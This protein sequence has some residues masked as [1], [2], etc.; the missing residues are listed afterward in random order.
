MS[1]KTVSK[2]DYDTF[3]YLTYCLMDKIDQS[4]VDTIDYIAAPGRGGL[5][6]GV[7][8]SHYFNKPFI[9]VVWSNKDT[10]LQHHN[11]F[12]A[13]KLYT[14]S[15]ILLVKNISNSGKTLIEITK[16]LMYADPHPNIPSGQLYT[17]TVFQR[18]NSKFQCAFFGKMI[19]DETWIQ[20]PWESV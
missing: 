18:H 3:H 11:E 10:T 9:P 15:N 20:F 19:D 4:I 14:G 13:E 1:N 16:D 8:I 7:I 12:L 6:P 5:L 17:S 2:I